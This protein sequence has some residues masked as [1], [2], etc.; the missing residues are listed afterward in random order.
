MTATNLKIRSDKFDTMEFE[1][2]EDLVAGEMRK[3]EDTVVV[4]MAS[5]DS[6]DDAL[7]VY[8]CTRIIVPKTAASGI[9]FAQFDNVYF[10]ASAEAVTNSSGGNT[11][12]GRA[13]E[14]A[15]AAATEVMIDLKGNLAA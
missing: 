1:A 2:S 3:I 14:A 11:L 5:V 7:G 15:T 6:G 10:D 4:V 13:L 12:I 9:T 8:S